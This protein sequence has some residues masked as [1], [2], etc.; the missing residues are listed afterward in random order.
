MFTRF[1]KSQQNNYSILC[2]FILI[3]YKT[4]VI[5]IITLNITTCI[6]R[7]PIIVAMATT[8]Q[9]HQCVG[10]YSPKL[11]TVLEG[12]AA[13]RPRLQEVEHCL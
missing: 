7:C 3:N 8:L 13:D 11:L 1:L 12:T 4:N 5:Y 10:P 6:V 2:I 9:H